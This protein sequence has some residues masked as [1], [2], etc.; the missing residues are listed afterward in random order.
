MTPEQRELMRQ[1][2]RNLLAHH[3]AGRKCDPQALKWAHNV[4]RKDSDG[5]GELLRDHQDR[6]RSADALPDR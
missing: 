5:G 4:L 2:A 3:E 6:G 1:A